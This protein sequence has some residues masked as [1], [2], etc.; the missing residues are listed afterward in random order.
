MH[1]CYRADGA[2]H[3]TTVDLFVEGV[4]INE[5]VIGQHKILEAICRR[6]FLYY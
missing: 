5:E 3:S 2:T 1:R 6:Q 4:I